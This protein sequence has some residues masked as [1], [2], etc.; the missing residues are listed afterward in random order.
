MR[1]HGIGNIK[2]FYPTRHGGQSQQT[3]QRLSSLLFRRQFAQMIVKSRCRVVLGQ[4][5]Q[6]SFH[7]AFG[8]QNPN[9]P[10]LLL[11]EPALNQLTIGQ[12]LRH[13]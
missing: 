9:R 3:L 7:A 12:R 1:A 13:E 2:P 6:S 4:P 10:P 8:S 5:E 11:A